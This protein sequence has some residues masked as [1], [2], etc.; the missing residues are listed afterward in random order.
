MSKDSL[1]KERF[2]NYVDKIILNNKLSHAYLIE[3][4]NYDKDL[5]YVY[6]FIKMILC[7]V[8]YN[9]LSSCN[10]PIINQID[11]NNYPDIT[12]ISTDNSVIKKGQ[13]IDL[14]KEFSNKSLLNNKRIYI[15]F[16]S[17]KLNTSSANTIL[18]FLE[19]PEDDIIAFLLTDN[20]Y[21][22][23]DT[24]LSRC[25][26]LSLKENNNII[27]SDDSDLDF[28][29]C[30]INPHNFY[31]KYNYFIINIIP[32]KDIA[33][34]KFINVENIIINYLN[35]KYCY[36]N[37]DNDFYIL[38]DKVDN[39]KLINIIS[40]I[41]EYIVKLDFNINYK[42]WLDAIFSRFVGGIYD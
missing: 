5:S 20:R 1:V 21:H 19:E 35:S 24:L 39:N 25:Q 41:E 18:K 33:K 11:N 6:S 7:D 29:D 9:E 4:D 17:E 32:D 16:Q 37:D 30:V 36:H 28:L 15:I 31:I 27:N 26:V 2:I 13:L 42:L 38:L 34:N 22:V 40:I 3:L 12:I 8:S 14:Q 10:N 23:L